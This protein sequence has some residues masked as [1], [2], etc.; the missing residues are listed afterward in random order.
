LFE[1]N[2]LQA[3]DAEFGEYFLLA[4]AKIEGASAD[5]GVSGTIRR[6]L[7][8]GLLRTAGRHWRF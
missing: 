1:G 4:D 3:G 8:N 5:L 6:S 2:S 7:D